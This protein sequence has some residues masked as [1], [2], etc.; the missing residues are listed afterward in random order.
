M[1]VD[2]AAIARFDIAD[3]SGGT[4]ISDATVTPIKEAKENSTDPERDYYYA[5]G[6]MR[7]SFATSGTFGFHA[8][9]KHFGRSDLVRKI[10]MVPFQNSIRFSDMVIPNTGIPGNSLNAGI[11][12]MNDASGAWIVYGDWGLRINE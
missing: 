11:P 12:T 4:A 1:S 9:P 5:F 7:S 3:S 6:D 2:L 8:L 10:N